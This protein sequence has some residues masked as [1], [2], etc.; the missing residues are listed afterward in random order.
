LDR[1]NSGGAGGDIRGR[2][3]AAAGRLI[4]QEKQ[5]LSAAARR[6]AGPGV[7]PY[8]TAPAPPAPAWRQGNVFP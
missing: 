7:F 6:L 5:S 2:F 1:R 4:P 3:H 8:N